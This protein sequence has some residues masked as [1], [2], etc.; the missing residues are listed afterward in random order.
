VP[1]LGATTD[2]A[3][4]FVLAVP[5]ALLLARLVLTSNAIDLL[6]ELYEAFPN[7]IR[8]PDGITPK[9]IHWSAPVVAF[10]GGGP[11]I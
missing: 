9:F 4:S 7:H 11:I 5:L 1:F 3:K 6:G 10:P 8:L 2:D